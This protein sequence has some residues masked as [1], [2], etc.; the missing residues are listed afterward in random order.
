MSFMKDIM[1]LNDN[2]NALVEKDIKLDYAQ[3]REFCKLSE[4]LGLVLEKPDSEEK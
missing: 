2:I 1:N 4:E 3:F